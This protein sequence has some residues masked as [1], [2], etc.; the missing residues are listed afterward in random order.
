MYF[1]TLYMPIFLK[2]KGFITF[3]VR[4]CTTFSQLICM[5][6][7]SSNIPGKNWFSMRKN[8]HREHTTISTSYMGIWKVI[9][10]GKKYI[11][12]LKMTYPYLGVH[13]QFCR[14]SA[15]SSSFNWFLEIFTNTYGSF[16][17]IRG[18]KKIVKIRFWLF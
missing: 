10:I 2:K 16:S 13:I 15:K 7:I 6:T 3:Y 17:K 14:W 18:K 9:F 12:M 1:R 11:L 4:S 5:C 8:V